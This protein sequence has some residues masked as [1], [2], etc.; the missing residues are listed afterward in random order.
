MLGRMLGQM[1]VA[2]EVADAGGSGGGDAAVKMTPAGGGA[3]GSIQIALTQR[4]R[5]L[6][7]LAWQAR[8]KETQSTKPQRL[9]LVK[10]MQGQPK[11]A[12]ENDGERWCL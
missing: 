9:V 1:L 4:A 10:R 5:A 11:R 8:G 3:C 7:A 12:L 6:S 2:V